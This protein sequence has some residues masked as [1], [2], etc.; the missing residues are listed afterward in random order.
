MK[1]GNTNKIALIIFWVIITF[2]SIFI[3]YLICGAIPKTE[4][5]ELGYGARFL[6]VLANPFRGYFN[7]YSLIGMIVGFIISEVIFGLVFLLKYSAASQVDAD[8]V[9]VSEMTRIKEENREKADSREEIDEEVTSEEISLDDNSED[10][11]EDD[12]FA[13]DKKKEPKED[14]NKIKKIWSRDREKQGE[15]QEKEFTMSQDVF[16]N[17]YNQGYTNEQI[18]AMMEVTEYIPDIDV[19]LLTRM[20]KKDMDPDKIRESIEILYG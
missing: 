3:G 12:V 4:G 13:E 15:E 16:L 19:S 5:S 20:F 10:Y 7:D 1:K 9:D 18:K 6:E 17:L 11:Y 2:L 8:L 14:T